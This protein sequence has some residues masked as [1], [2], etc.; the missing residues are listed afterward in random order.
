MSVL[1]MDEAAIPLSARELRRGIAA[2]ADTEMLD[3][4]DVLMQAGHA[5]EGVRSRQ[6]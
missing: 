6:S 3:L 2:Y 5:L 4:R 1:S